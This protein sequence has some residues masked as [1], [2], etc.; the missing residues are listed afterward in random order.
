MYLKVEDRTKCKAKSFRLHFD[1]KVLP[2][3]DETIE[4]YKIY[5]NSTL[6]VLPIMNGGG[7][8]SSL[9]SECAGCSPPCTYDGHE[10]GFTDMSKLIEKEEYAYKVLCHKFKFSYQVIKDIEGHTDSIRV[11]LHDVLHRFHHIGWTVTF[12]DVDEILSNRN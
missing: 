4:D 6:F 8:I 11:R 10:L 1:G 12:E 2:N 3:N 5:R 7:S 9:V